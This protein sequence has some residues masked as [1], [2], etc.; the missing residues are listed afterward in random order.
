MCSKKSGEEDEAANFLSFLLF[1]SPFP[2]QH[3]EH[4]KTVQILFNLLMHRVS[5]SHD[6]LEE[7]LRR[8]GRYEYINI[9]AFELP[10]D[11]RN[12]YV[13]T[14]FQHNQGGRIYKKYLEHL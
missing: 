8:Y 6:F 10:N 11:I 4:A 1:P 7:C 14:L 5:Q 3:F 2:K 13:N 12:V 9:T